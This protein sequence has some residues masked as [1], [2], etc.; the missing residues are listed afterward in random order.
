MKQDELD[1][2]ANYMPII[3]QADGVSDW[4][5]NFCASMI[6]QDRKGTFDPS[7]KQ[8]AVM[9]RIVRDFQT[10]AENADVIEEENT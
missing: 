10:R 5:R 7:Y 9:K 6:A 1:R 4:E 8:I 3:V 2:L